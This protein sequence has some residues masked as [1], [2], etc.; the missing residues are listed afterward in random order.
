MLR[1]CKPGGQILIGDYCK[2]PQE[3]TWT[4]FMEWIGML[5]GDYPHDFQSLFRE[6]G[7]QPKIEL[8]G[9]SGMYQFIRVRKP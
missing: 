9:W 1:V 3:T 4:R 7:C 8:L 5:I 2:A 6:L